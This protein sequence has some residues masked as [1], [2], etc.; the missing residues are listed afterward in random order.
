TNLKKQGMLALT[1]AEKSDYDKIQED[2]SIDI[3]GLTDFAP[4]KPLTMV[5][6]H[7]DGSKDNI[8]VNH[9]Y[10]QQQIEWFKAGA[11]LNIIRRQVAG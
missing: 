11:A 2:D 7:A 8:Q 9:T 1:F 5:F 3:I 6:T 10:N 4:G